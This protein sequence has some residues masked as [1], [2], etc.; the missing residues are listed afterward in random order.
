M[1]T[2][3]MRF[4]LYNLGYDRSTISGLKPEDAHFIIENKITSD[5]YLFDK[6]NRLL[7]ESIKVIEFEK[8]F[9]ELILN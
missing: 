2:N 1:I 3:K 6:L 8:K 4:D 5:N 9:G 7:D